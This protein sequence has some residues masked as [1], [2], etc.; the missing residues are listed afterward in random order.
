MKNTGLN[1]AIDFMKRQKKQFFENF[2]KEND[3]SKMGFIEQKAIRL[4]ANKDWEAKETELYSL[5]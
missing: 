3:T 5:V 1:F 4:K 2:Y